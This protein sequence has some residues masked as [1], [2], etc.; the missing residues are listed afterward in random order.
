MDIKKGRINISVAIGFKLITM[1][2]AIVVKVVLVD[3]CGNEVNGLNALYISIIGMLSVAELGA[4]S[5]IA[6]CM[7]KPIVDGENETVSALYHLFKKLYRLIGLFIFCVGLAITPFL[8]FFASDYAEIDVNLYVTFV[9][10]L[11][12]VAAT[13]LY[14]AN[15]SLINAY[16]NNYITTAISQ[17]GLV[18]LYVVQ[19]LVLYV[20]KSFV[21]YLICRLVIVMIQMMVTHIVT[22]KKYGDIVKTTAKLDAGTMKMVTK[23]IKAMFVHKI[24]YVLVNTVD[25]V[26]I[27]SFVGV[28]SLGEYSNYTTILTAMTGVI[29][30]VFSS[31]TSVIG[32]LCVEGKA[33][34]HQYCESFQ[35]LNFSIG[36]VFFLGY[37][38][39]IDSLIATLFS[40][41]LVVTNSISLVITLNGFVQFMRRNT[42]TFR[43]A[44]G[45]FYD[46]R[47]KPL[48]EGGVNI[49]LSILL[50]KR[51][52]ITGVIVATIIT[53]M[54]IC[55]I[56]EPYVL[57]KNAF[58]RPVYKY[59][60]K[61]YIMIFIFAIALLAT[62]ACL[63]ET[64]Y[65]WGE[66][67]LNGMIS[68]GISFVVC[69]VWAVFNKKDAIRLLQ[70]LRRG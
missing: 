68:L 47:W 39:V 53:N 11:T 35:L 66:F 10:L 70:I 12:S 24:G 2:L 29:N 45:S 36:T 56:V 58:D 3:I 9:L 19:I 59:C 26:V 13:Y 49:V 48:V 21:C 30:L 32:H 60:L 20:T 42:L 43:D 61:N 27:S 52:G 7:Y 18:L 8:H 54:V 41:D 34:A 37:Y 38:A 50:V 55:H 46:D 51:I 6:F 23:S 62:N 44:T 64:L 1:V 22:K 57:Y 67:F 31:I 33:T 63:P 25:S 16:K 17:G 28:I 65:G 69:G 15:T 40:P 5:A 4:G 14:S